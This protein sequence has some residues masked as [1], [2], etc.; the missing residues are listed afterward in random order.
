MGFKDL[1]SF[2]AK[3]EEEGQLVEYDQPVKLSP[4]WYD[5]VRSLPRLGQ[6][7][8]ALITDQLEGYK[9]QRICMGVHA[10]PANCALMLGLPKDT[11]LKEQVLYMSDLWDQIGDASDAK[12]KWVDD[13]ACQEVVIEG[14]DI[15]L[16]ENLPLARVYP[17]DGGFYF[18]RAAVVTKSLYYPDDFDR[19]NVGTYRCQ[20]IGPREIALHV[21]PLHDGGEHIGQA[22]SLGK[23]CPVAICFGNDPYL[24]LMSNTS[25]KKYESEYKYAAAM[26]GVEYE[27][28]LT[29]LD[30][31]PVPANSEIIIEGEILPFER[32][33]EGPF[34]EFTGSYS[35]IDE[36]PIIKV[37]RITTRANPIYVGMC[38]AGISEKE[39]EN[40]LTL[41]TSSGL[42]RQLKDEMPD[43]KAINASYQHGMT[44][45][46]SAK[47]HCPGF[48][49]TIA[50]RIASTPHGTDYCR[51]IIVVD[52]KVDPFNLNEVMW[53]MSTRVRG[54]EDI[55][56]IPGTPGLPLLPAD[57]GI[58]IGRKL[59][60]DATTPIDPDPFRPTKLLD[61]YRSSVDLRSKIRELQDEAQ[62]QLAQ[63]K[64]A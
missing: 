59:I 20:V 4:E 11:P 54:Q 47:P 10:S 31:L 35:G 30:Q 2:L 8:P 37:K 55:I 41:N 13:P 27:M 61:T 57:L 28:A 62:K 39:S 64:E 56:V 40:M 32:T 21:S 50:M 12:L 24:D 45:I 44:T 9:G 48:A 43:I 5:M 7:G 15:N 29:M 58:K 33:V 34:G 26:A 46:V 3:L 53:A 38:L 25:L 60:I 17:G 22:E 6:N 49:K 14:D 19:V 16:W 52:D 36:A 23:A 1:R 51:N 18:P 63:D 42:Y